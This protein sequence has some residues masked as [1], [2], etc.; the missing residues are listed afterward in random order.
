MNGIQTIQ[1]NIFLAFFAKHGFLS[2]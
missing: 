1:N 2:L